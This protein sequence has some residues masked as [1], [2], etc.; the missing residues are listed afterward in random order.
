MTTLDRFET[1]EILHFSILIQML[2]FFLKPRFFELRF[3]I[4]VKYMLSTSKYFYHI[5]F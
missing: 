1:F 4:L 3:Y 5:F 2:E